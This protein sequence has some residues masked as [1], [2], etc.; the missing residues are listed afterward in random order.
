M[1]MEK[2][3]ILAS[4]IHAHDDHTVTGRVRLQKTVRLLQRMGLPT[5]YGFRLH[6]HGPY[7]EDAQ[8]DVALLES[9]GIVTESHGDQG[10]VYTA[11]DSALLADLGVFQYAVDRMQA[12]DAVCLELAATYDAYR[13]MGQDHAGALESMRRKKSR[14]WTQGCEDRALALLEEFSLL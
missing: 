7:S 1:P 8:A 3:R 11:I 12:E 9:L 13:E 6:F 4:V 5:D 14:K 2:F 10:Y